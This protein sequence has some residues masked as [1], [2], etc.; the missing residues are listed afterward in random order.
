MRKEGAFVPLPSRLP[1]LEKRGGVGCLL[2]L[3][4]PKSP[5]LREV[6]FVALGTQEEGERE[7]ESRPEG[8][9]EGRKEGT[10]LHLDSGSGGRSRVWSLRV[11]LSLS[12][13][14]SIGKTLEPPLPF[15]LYYLVGWRKEETE[16]EGGR[17]DNK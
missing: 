4:P 14:L 8:E 11:P 12:L 2:L 7:R 9:K 1:L 16:I 6:F 17:E 5:S 13:S 10:Q 3:P 15:I